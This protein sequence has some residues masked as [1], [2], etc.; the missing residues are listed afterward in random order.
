MIGIRALASYVP[1][2]GISNFDR[3]EEFGLSDEFITEKLGVER[4]SRM[5]AGEGTVSLCLRAFAVLQQKTAVTPDEIDLIV[6]CTQNPDGGGLPHNSALVHGAIG[7]PEQCAAFDL[8]LGCSGY[9]YGLSVVKSFMEANGLRHGLLFTADP[10]SRIVDPADRNTALLFG[11]AASVTLLSDGPGEPLWEPARFLFATAGQQAD[12]LRN[13]DGRLGMNGRAVFTFS[14]TSVPT[15][16]RELMA[17]HGVDSASVDLFLFHQG[18]KYIVDALASRLGLPQDKVPCNLAA[19][20]NTVS[21][22]IPLLFE[23]YVSNPSLRRVLM[24]GF[25]VGL[26]WA[27]CIVERRA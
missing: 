6:V 10:Y 13:R 5:A 27:S 14:A 15:Q 8:G 9:V 21:S 18:S 19:Q 2:G 3:R 1:S 7:V 26:S 23:R 12:A 20:G 16:V 17:R 4:V 24:C 25:G 22:S 11:D